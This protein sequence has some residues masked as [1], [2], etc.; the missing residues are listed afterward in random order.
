M[1]Q[2]NPYKKLFAEL[3][4]TVSEWRKPPSFQSYGP[5]TLFEYINGGAELYLSYG[6][7][8][9]LS[10][11][12]TADN[13]PDIMV[14]IFDM[15]NSYRAYG[16]F[17]HSR[18]TCDDSIGQGCE[19]GGGLMIFWKGQYYVSILAYP[20]TEDARQ[21]IFQIARK[22]ADS[23]GEKGV[24]PPVLN[25]LPQKHLVRE[26][27]RYFNHYIWLNS[28]YFISNDNILHIDQQT[29]AVL[30]QY[31]RKSGKYFLLL[32]VYP[33]SEKAERACSDFR[34]QYLN[35][36][37]YTIKRI[38]ENSWAGCKIDENRLW[39]IFNAVSKKRITDIFN[40]ISVE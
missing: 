26:T 9:L 40:G 34:K 22:I 1:A 31:A 33:N 3:P 27:I 2:H 5:S 11:Q 19:Y 15:G 4:D 35:E 24:L 38:K 39:L 23:I 36:P 30:A 17:S 12:Y 6:F 28:H 14:D 8:H 18:E 29:E 13:L 32:V 21:C 7:K 20:E 16:I 37:S 10:C 25:R